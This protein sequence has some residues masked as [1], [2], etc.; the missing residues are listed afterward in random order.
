MDRDEISAEVCRLWTA[1]ER[2]RWAAEVVRGLRISDDCKRLMVEVGLP[3]EC[4]GPEG[5]T[6]C[7]S[8]LEPLSDARRCCR[9]LNRW[10]GSND[11]VYFL[12]EEKDGRLCFLMGEREVFVN[13]SV[14]HFA[15][16]WVAYKKYLIE[17]EPIVAQKKID[18][19]RYLELFD[20]TE[21]ELRRIDPAAWE[22]M[23]G[24]WRRRRDYYKLVEQYGDRLY[25]PD[26]FGELNEYYP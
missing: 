22:D 17:R 23:P 13:A 21:R 1:D 15:A 16:C 11:M 18:M 20:R 25:W 24:D 4:F 10:V 2:F 7:V 3:R 5:R 6:V 12:D 26:C 14:M 19:E 9:V 8:G